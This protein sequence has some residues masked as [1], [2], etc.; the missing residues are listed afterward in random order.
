MRS[1]FL[2]PLLVTFGCA[3]TGQTTAPVNSS[4]DPVPV[5]IAALESGAQIAAVTADMAIESGDFVGCLV[6]DS[7]A[8]A[9]STGAEGVSG[10][11]SGNSLPSV[12]LELGDCF[13]IGESPEAVEIDDSVAGLVN[14]SL[15]AVSSLV[16]AYSPQMSCEAA[17][18]VEA[19][20][21]YA[22][23]VT[24]AVISEL[25]EPNGSVSIPAVEVD[26]CDPAEE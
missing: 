15:S 25:Q 18:W 4:F 24:S 26:S 13:E 10:N 5:V 23:G 21:Q 11:L 12:E 19:S 3:K 7:L 1:L 17:A 8:A 16:A 6:G 14:I 9:L 20:V 22:Q 2:L